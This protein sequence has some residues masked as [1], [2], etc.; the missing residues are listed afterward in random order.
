MEVRDTDTGGPP[1]L[2][3]VEISSV[4]G[5]EGHHLLGQS[6]GS[7]F[8]FLLLFLDMDLSATTEEVADRPIDGPA[9]RAVQATTWRRQFT[10]LVTILRTPTKRVTRRALRIEGHGWGATRRCRCFCLQTSRAPP[11]LKV[12]WV[13]ACVRIPTPNPNYTQPLPQPQP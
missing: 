5:R 1:K 10:H 8:H 12:G 6:L 7:V 9:R 11:Q 2:K 4:S 13:I 3:S